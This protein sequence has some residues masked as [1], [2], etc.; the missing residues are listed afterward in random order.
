ME[1]L[2]RRWQFKKSTNEYQRKAVFL[3]G[4]KPEESEKIRKFPENEQQEIPFV[5]C[6]IMKIQTENEAVSV[7]IS[8]EQRPFYL[9]FAS[10]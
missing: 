3:A 4:S 5:I 6:C 10:W 7:I 9:L 1:N 2:I 8:R